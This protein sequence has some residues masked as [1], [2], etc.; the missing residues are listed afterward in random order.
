VDERQPFSFDRKVWIV[1][2]AR[3]DARR[4]LVAELAAKGRDAALSRPDAELILH[5]YHAWGEACVD[6]LSGDFAFV[7]WDAPHRRWFGTRDHFGIKPFY[8]AMTGSTVV[9]SNTLDCIRLHPGV[10]SR[11]NE[12]S[13]ADFLLFEYNRDKG[14]TFFQEIHCIPP[15]HTIVWTPQGHRVRQYWSLP[16]DEP[17]RYKK[18]DEYTEHFRELLREAVGDRMRLPRTGVFMSGGLDSPALAA[19][20][21]EIKGPGSVCAFTHVFDGFGQ[22][23]HYAGLVAKHLGIDIL[24]RDCLAEGVDPNWESGGIHTNAPPANPMLLDRDW[25]F[26]QKVSGSQRVILCGEG[27]DAALHYEWRPYLDYL[28]QNHRWRSLIRESLLHMLLHR[29]LPLLSTIP[30]AMRERRQE[31][32]WTSGYPVWLNPEFETRL[33]LRE[34]WAE[35]VPQASH[36]VR[37]VGYNALLRARWQA[38]FEELDPCG[39]GAP[40]EF[41]HPYF[42]IRV[43]RFMLAVPALPWCRRKYLLRRAMRGL[44]P[45]PILQRD[46]APLY[47]DPWTAQAAKI[48]IAPINSTPELSSYV[49]GTKVPSGSPGTLADFRSAMQ[50][51][52]LNYWLINVDRLLYTSP[53]GTDANGGICQ[54]EQRRTKVL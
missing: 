46:K 33:K 22:E 43:L 6:H 12:S 27:P 44:L 11:R 50:P 48:G 45:D 21:R 4:N 41:R 34:R 9:V 23:R 16:V 40:L 14:E 42:D 7:I 10:S 37:P 53:G 52:S 31:R 3:I 54:A 49:D 2:D 25:S 17:L 5:A 29:R 20:A 32:K 39:T 47:P 38:Y 8:Y 15:A 35:E 28:A 18:L 19:T 30:R 51:R 36:P 1:A 13:I 26:F 24:F